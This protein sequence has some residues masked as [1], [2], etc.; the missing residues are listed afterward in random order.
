M[1]NNITLVKDALEYYDA[2]NEKYRFVFKGARYVKFIPS[3]NDLEHNVV[4]F[5]NDAK[6]EMFRSRFEV[7]GLFNSN[8]NTWSWAWSIPTYRKNNTHIV[9]QIFMYG[10]ELD[11]DESTRFLK[12]ELITSRFRISD[13]VQLDVHASIASFLSHKPVIYN[14]YL[15]TDYQTGSDGLYDITQTTK[16][17]TLHYIFLL[18]YAQ[19]DQKA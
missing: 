4:V 11:P 14:H 16:Q 12:M 8:S 6:E 15:F 3:K 13:P 7:I 9:R 10:S 18:D 1:N 2:N 17:Y 19:F 5:Y